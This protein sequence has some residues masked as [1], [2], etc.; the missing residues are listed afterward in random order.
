MS[1]LTCS[2]SGLSFRL[3]ESICGERSTRV[4]AKC[5]LRGNELLPPPEPSSSTGRG[6]GLADL[7]RA[8]TRGG[9]SRRDAWG[10]EERGDHSPP[11]A[12]TLLWNTVSQ[13]DD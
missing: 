10:P 6:G 12:W 2:H 11:S 4:I 7:R 3:T 1:P 13:R 5:A 8:R 9:A